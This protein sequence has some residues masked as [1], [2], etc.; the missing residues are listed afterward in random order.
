MARQYYC[1]SLARSFPIHRHSAI[2]SLTCC[3]RSRTESRSTWLAWRERVVSSRQGQDCT[4]RSR[5]LGNRDVVTHT[6]CQWDGMHGLMSVGAFVATD[7][8]GCF[9][10]TLQNQHK[11]TMVRVEDQPRLH[12][13][14]H[15]Q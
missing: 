1:R 5:R 4:R 12:R 15:L 3:L 11:C 7:D 2:S 8:R 10:F 9:H 14:V 13:S 6:C